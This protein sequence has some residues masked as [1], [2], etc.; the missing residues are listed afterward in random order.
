MLWARW[1]FKSKVFTR[2]D[3]HAVDADTELHVQLPEPQL[4]R[5]NVRVSSRLV[6]ALQLRE[7]CA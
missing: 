6:Q 1:T 2:V 5:D 7:R 4:L 3:L